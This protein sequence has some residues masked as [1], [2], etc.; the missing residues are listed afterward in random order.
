MPLLPP[1]LLALQSASGPQFSVRPLAAAAAGASSS[2]VVRTLCGATEKD[3]IVE[4]N[5]GG[6]VVGDFD[7]DGDHDLVVVDGST[8]DRVRAGASGQPPRLY[9]N[10]GNGEFSA[11]GDEWAMDGGRWGMGGTAGD[12]DG[13]GFLDLVITEWGPDRV[14]LNRPTE[15][16]GRGFVEVTA[17]AGLRGSAWGTS[18]ALFDRERDGQL[19]LVIVNYL[20]AR[21]EEIEDGTLASRRDERCK[22][23]G[24]PVMCGPEGLIPLHDRLYAGNGD[25]TFADVSVPAGFRPSQAGFGLGVTTLDHDADGDTDLYVTN[26]STPNHLWENQ[27]DGTF[28]EMGER[29]RVALDMNG[30]EQAGMG[31]AVADLNEDGFQDLFVTNFSGENNSLYLSRRSRGGPIYNERASQVRVGGP[32]IP[33]LGWGPGLI[34][35]DLDSDL[36]LFVLNGHVYPQADG[37]G[38]DTSYAQQ[39]QLFRNLGL[40]EGGIPGFEL[41]SLDDGAARVSRAGVPVDLDGDGD[42]DMLT[43]ELDGAVQR[44]ENLA[45]A[46]NWLVVRLRARDGNTQALG[47]LVEARLG[48]RTLLRE[49]RT[50][51]GFQAAG[52]AEAHFGLGAADEVDEL[53]VRWPS[54]QVTRHPD[55]AARQVL[56]LQE[57]ARAESVEERSR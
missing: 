50:S 36:D 44:L 16:G 31:I 26:D 19:D 42:Q 9:L 51:A 20:S 2:D 46:G 3:Y 45:G 49:I 39:D 38:T 24:F 14:F 30:K 13:D 54:G 53:V 28:V 40:G 7:G 1:I 6:L 17:S 43:I 55:V 41:E 33:F 22:W 32:S 25:G 29:R 18:A 11:A 23:K 15:T 57:P 52:P 10:D 37:V 27:G 47:A 34:D 21:L 8:L 56:I 12:V 35:V 4:V 48:E 5:G